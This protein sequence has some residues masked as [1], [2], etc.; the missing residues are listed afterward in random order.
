MNSSKYSRSSN[1]EYKPSYKSYWKKKEPPYS[2]F[3][4]NIPPLSE[5]LKENNAIVNY[6][7]FAN[8]NLKELTKENFNASI[9]HIISCLNKSESK[10]EEDFN[11]KISKG[12]IINIMHYGLSFYKSAPVINLLI[13]IKNRKETEKSENEED[14][15]DCDD[16][17]IFYLKR[18]CKDFKKFEDFLDTMVLLTGYLTKNLVKNNFTEEENINK[19]NEP[20]KEK[21]KEKDEE[22]EKETEKEKPPKTQTQNTNNNLIL[23]NFIEMII[24]YIYNA[25]RYEI[26]CLYPI[27]S[28]VLSILCKTNTQPACELLLNLLYLY[29]INFSTSAINSY[30]DFLCRNN[31]LEECHELLSNMVK[32]IPEYSLPKDIDTFLKEKY[33]E[34]H[35]QK[36]EGEKEMNYN[37]KINCEKNL[38]SYGINIVSFGIY[39]KYLCKNDYLDLALFYYEQLNKNNILKDEVIYNLLLNGCSKKLDIRNLH[40]IYMDMI[41]KGISPN[42][43]TFNTIID[44]FIRNKNTEKAFSIFNDMISNKINPDNFTLSTLFKGINKPEHYQYLIQGVDIINKNIYPVDIILI[45]VLL[46]ACIKLKDKKNFCEIFE[47]IINKK[48]K[49]ISPDLITYNTFIKGC[50]KF[51][52]YDKVEFAFNHLINNSKKTNIIPNDVTFNSLLDVYVSQKDM[53]KVF[54]IVKL[55]NEFK[56]FP[57][58]YTY[59]TIIKGLNKNSLLKASN[60]NNIIANNITNINPNPE[61]EEM[62][63][64]CELNLAFKLFNQVKMSSKPDEILYNCIMDACLRFNK[65][66]KMLEVYQEMIKDGIKPSSIT[67]GIVIKAYGMKGDLNSALDIYYKMKKEKIEI[68]NIT[69]GCLINACI[70]NNDLN[71]AFELYESLKNES[72]EMNTI[73]YTTLIKAYSKQ[74]DINKVIEIFNTMKQSQN[75]KPNIITYNSII[76]CCIKCDKFNLAYEYFQEMLFDINNTSENSIRPDIVTF[77]TLIKG[78]INNKCFGNARKLMQKL[79]EYNYI[80]LDCVL[81]NT[82]LDGCDKCHCYEEALDIFNIFKNKNVTCNM[83][84]Y[85]ILMKICGKLN[86]FENSYKLLNEMKE[87]NIN[88]NLIIMTCYIKTCLNTN[89]VVEGINTFK[90]MTKY[91]IYPD[92][93]AYTTIISGIINNFELCDYSDE[94]VKFLKK[95]VE[96]NIP[97]NKS[98]F[99]KGFYYLNLLGHKDKADD[100]SEFLKEKNLV[101]NYSSNDKGSNNSKSNSNDS[102][103]SN[104]STNN[105]TINSTITNFNTQGFNYNYSYLNTINALNMCYYQKYCMDKYNKSNSNNNKKETPLKEIFENNKIYPFVY[106]N[107]DNEKIGQENKEV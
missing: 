18:L 77:S 17:I 16:L 15:Y 98:L 33:G 4:Y 12:A 34:N 99:M 66:D 72:Y 57:D 101:Y 56:I 47:N 1:L 45:N 40:R 25:C 3:S 5:F 92:N 79:L 65:I 43:I 78:E 75:S 38:V 100:L 83:M 103:N 81:L 9:D 96:E 86:D 22:K 90:E 44:A 48:Y 51:K 39:L 7:D 52:L 20:E 94:L 36:E 74:K 70:K 55:M 80:K 61:T 89:H 19:P 11:K 14:Y 30:I 93:I 105:K 53:Y 67:C 42:L 68:S 8:I 91:N 26:F 21:D 49:N 87:N 62:L 13:N 46:D 102:N 58:N 10:K 76:D 88:F 63:S 41:A 23:S 106:K 107:K 6:I 71:K 2:H 31:Y 27:L 29:N 60:G 104:E 64:N 35:I 95:S 32:Y 59:T 24:K 37:F 50:S 69:Y 82:L 73:L 97:I 85:S 28:T 54:Q 84:T